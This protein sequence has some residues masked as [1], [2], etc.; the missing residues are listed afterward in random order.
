MSLG[1]SRP[2]AV[3]GTT[4]GGQGGKENSW[5]LTPPSFSKTIQRS[6]QNA[7]FLIFLLKYP[8]YRT[9]L[10]QFKTPSVSP[11]C[12]SFAKTLWLWDCKFIIAPRRAPDVSVYF[13]R[14]S[15]DLVS[16]CLVSARKFPWFQLNIL[17]TKNS[18]IT[19]YINEGKYHIT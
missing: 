8:L 11:A 16:K 14:F 2:T 17:I 12:L 18:K 6:S 13:L 4:G 5:P 3:G 1:A 15:R 9:L 7:P 10:H 19:I